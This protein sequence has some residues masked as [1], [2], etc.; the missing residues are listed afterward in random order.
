MELDCL[1]NRHFNSLIGV[2]IKALL[3]AEGYA[4]GVFRQ[5]IIML[6]VNFE[7]CCQPL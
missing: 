6:R 2:A 7:L 5:S 4:T 1:K 3:T